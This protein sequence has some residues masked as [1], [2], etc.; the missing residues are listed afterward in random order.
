MKPAER[1]T[2]SGNRRRFARDTG[3]M[4]ALFAK[5]DGKGLI[6][7]IAAPKGEGSVAMYAHTAARCIPS[8]SVMSPATYRATAKSGPPSQGEERA[9]VRVGTFCHPSQ[10]R[11]FMAAISPSDQRQCINEALGRQE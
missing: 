5:G 3:A 8:I 7:R 10:K 1:P 9:H 6:R 11:A 4:N 2:T